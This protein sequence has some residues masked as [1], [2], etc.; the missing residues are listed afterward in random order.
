MTTPLIEP[1]LLLAYGAATRRVEKGEFL[2]MEGASPRYYHQVFTGQVKMVCTNSEGKD[3]IFSI[4]GPGQSFGEPPLLIDEKYPCTATAIMPSIILR[5]PRA[6]FFQLLQENPTLVQRLLVVMAQRVYEKAKTARILSTPSPEEK[7]L[8][9]LRDF[10]KSSTQ[11]VLIPYTRQ[12]IA[13]CIGLRVETVIR[14]LRRMAS[15]NKLAIIRHKLF[16]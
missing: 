16:Y 5:L 12:Q 14:T 9:F 15:E 4:F 6:A 8:H 13:D 7:I 3:L 10:K 2:F 1:D 11:P